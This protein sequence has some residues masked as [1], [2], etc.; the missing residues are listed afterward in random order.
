M[1]SSL[2]LRCHAHAHNDP[3][4]SLDYRPVC[5]RARH[6]ASRHR[7][8]L[9]RRRLRLTDWLRRCTQTTSLRACVRASGFT[10]H[11]LGRPRTRKHAAPA[12]RLLNY[13]LCS[14]RVCRGNDVWTHTLIIGV[15]YTHTHRMA[16]L[17]RRRRG[18]IVPIAHRSLEL[19]N[20]HVFILGANSPKTSRHCP[21]HLPAGP[22]VRCRP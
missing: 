16:A 1:C 10:A 19:A 21:P 9:N 20:K 12:M 11:R 17:L 15:N 2:A 22:S 5:A 18:R 4:S 3:P 7:M 14:C 8:R 6:P 13:A